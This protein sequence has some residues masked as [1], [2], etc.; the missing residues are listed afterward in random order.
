[1]LPTVVLKPLCDVWNVNW[2]K[3]EEVVYW[4]T[5]SEILLNPVPD[6]NMYLK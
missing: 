5:Q 1:M 4:K 3:R 2:S 6:F